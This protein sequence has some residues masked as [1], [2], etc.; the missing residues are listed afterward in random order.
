MTVR[1]LNRRRQCQITAKAKDGS[2]RS[3]SSNSSENSDSSDQQKKITTKK[4]FFHQQ[5]KFQTQ[6]K[7]NRDKNEKL[8]I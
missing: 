6:K 4:N 7:A 2:D 5:T 8:K 1:L 3:D